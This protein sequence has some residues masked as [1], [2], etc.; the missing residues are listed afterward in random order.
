MSEQEEI[1]AKEQRKNRNIK[2]EGGGA[3]G[4]INIDLRTV[5]VRKGKNWNIR[6]KSNGR[7]I[8]W[9]T[10]HGKD[11]RKILVNRAQEKRRGRRSKGNNK[12]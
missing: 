12:Y 1:D 3:R 7:I 6:G 2:S 9:E 4:I 5:S 10:T 11:K 8:P